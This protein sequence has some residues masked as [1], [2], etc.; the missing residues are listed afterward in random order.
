MFVQLEHIVLGYRVWT[1]V[2]IGP[3]FKVRIPN[4][5]LKASRA[6]YS[7]TNQ[8]ECCNLRRDRLS[9]TKTTQ[10]DLQTRK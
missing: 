7:R 1:L 6:H 4:V 10:P 5:P 8:I 3:Y 2:I 9:M